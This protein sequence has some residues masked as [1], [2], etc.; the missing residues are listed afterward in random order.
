[1][2]AGGDANS[3]YFHN[4]MNSRGKRNCIKALEVKG[5]WIQDHVL[6]R[7]ATVGFFKNQSNGIGRCWLELRSQACLWRMILV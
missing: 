1:V 6:I 7:Q 4:C 3:R 5:G 2:V